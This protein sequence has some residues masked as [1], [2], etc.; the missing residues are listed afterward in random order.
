MAYIPEEQVAKAKEMDLLTWLQNYEPQELV[1]FSGNTYCTREHDSLKISNGKWYWF[2]RGIGGTSALDYLIKVREIPFAEAVAMILGQAALQPPVFAPRQQEKTEKKLRL[3][4]KNRS[5]ERAISYLE[6]RGIDRE[7]L[8][9]CVSTGRIYESFPHHSVVFVGFDGEKKP[10]YAAVRAVEGSFKGEA[11]GSDKSFSFS[12]PAE[13]SDTLHLF[14]SAI[15]LLSFATMAKITGR[16]WNAHHLL[17]LAGVY[18]PGKNRAESA[19]PLALSRFLAE[20][21]E[22]QNIVLRLDNDAPGRLAAAGLQEILASQY[23][24]HLAPPME[25]KDY[26]DFLCIRLG[27]PPPQ[28]NRSELHRKGGEAR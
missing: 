8:Q 24:V 11:T 15:D 20:H 17:S 25:G 10:R 12:I 22:V 14:E 23:Q 1:Q 5:C 13:N 6:H 7:L 21:P 28:C 2:S 9:F 3:P 4:Q 19:V 26:N 18:K 27:L 16:R